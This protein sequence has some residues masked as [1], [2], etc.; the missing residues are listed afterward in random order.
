MSEKQVKV[1]INQSERA[2]SCSAT[3]GW[4]LFY[5]IHGIKIGNKP[6]FI[7]IVKDN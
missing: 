2:V 3:P 7:F 4:G 6:E 5:D 1:P